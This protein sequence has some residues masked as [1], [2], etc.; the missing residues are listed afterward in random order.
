MADGTNVT[1]KSEQKLDGS[2]AAGT[3][4]KRRLSET[5]RSKEEIGKDMPDEERAWLELAKDAMAVDTVLKAGE[6]LYI[7]SHWFHYIISLQQ[8][9]QCN[10]RSGRNFEGSVEFGGYEDVKACGTE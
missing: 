6:V 1:V 5:T 10:V 4:T 3:D 8:S 2:E 7:P 9:A